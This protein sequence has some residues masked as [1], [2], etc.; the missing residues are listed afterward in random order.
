[1][2]TVVTQDS[3]EQSLSLESQLSVY[4]AHG[5]SSWMTITVQKLPC[6]STYAL[7]I[8]T[9]EVAPQCPTSQCLDL[10]TSW[11]ISRL[12]RPFSTG[13]YVAELSVNAEDI[14]ASGTKEPKTLFVSELIGVHLVTKSF[15]L[16]TQGRNINFTLLIPLLSEAQ[17]SIVYTKHMSGETTRF[18][19]NWRYHMS[20][21]ALIPWCNMNFTLG[22]HQGSLHDSFYQ[23]W[24]YKKLIS[25]KEA[26]EVCR[27]KKLSTLPEVLHDAHLVELTSH[28]LTYFLHPGHVFLSLIKQVQNKYVSLNKYF[29]ASFSPLESTRQ[30]DIPF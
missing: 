6:A 25:W 24:A 3:L 14:Q 12:T 17:S 16:K 27:E 21:A 7:E 18:C 8:N 19:V 29:I 23:T 30:L 15:F 22:N 2:S 5:S 20:F 28:L 26:F 13:I 10:S 1:M 11:N 4:F 9:P